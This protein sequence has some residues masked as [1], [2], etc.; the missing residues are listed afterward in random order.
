MF[1]EKH[2]IQKIQRTRSF[3]VA[4]PFIRF[5]YDCIQIN[6]SGRAFDLA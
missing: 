4:E 1:K 3:E 5:Y 6:Q 2:L